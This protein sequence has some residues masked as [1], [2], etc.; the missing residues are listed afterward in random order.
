MIVNDALI[1]NGK[2]KRRRIISDIFFGFNIILFLSVVLTP[3]SFLGKFPENIILN[4]LFLIFAF[5]II[6]FLP[7]CL[8]RK[9]VRMLANKDLRLIF[10]VPI[11]DPLLSFAILFSWGPLTPM[12]LG[13]LMLMLI[14][15]P[16]YFILGLIFSI[17]EFRRK[18]IKK[19]NVCV[20]L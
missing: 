3:E 5:Y 17:T 7:V 20:E 16:L 19:I 6:F 11:I 2:S 12:G 9:I 14:L 18:K 15:I 10:L 1:D 8:G 4:I 13:G